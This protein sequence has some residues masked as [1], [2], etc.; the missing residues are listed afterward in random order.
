MQLLYSHS[1][2]H[3]QITG[4]TSV[5]LEISGGARYESLVGL[6]ATNRDQIAS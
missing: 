6:Y 5:A 3:V 4:V 1:D 2:Y